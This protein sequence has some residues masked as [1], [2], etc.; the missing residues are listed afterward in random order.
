MTDSAGTFLFNARE[1]GVY[2]VLFGHFAQ[3]SG[4]VDTVSTLDAV[5]RQYLLGLRTASA[6]QPFCDWEVELPVETIAGVGAP[7]YPA[8][9]RSAGIEGEVHLQFVVDTAGRVE[10]ASAQVLYESAAVFTSAV[11]EALPRMRYRPA[12]L[13]GVIVRQVVTMP[14]L[15]AMRRGRRGEQPLSSRKLGACERS[16]S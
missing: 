16:F 3:L 11:L 15:F 14:F 4:P 1:S 6:E 2:Q 13:G 12:E 10:A 9:E 8:A 5:Q 7:R